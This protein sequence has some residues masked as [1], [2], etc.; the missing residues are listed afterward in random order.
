MGLVIGNLQL[1]ERE[2]L[3]HFKEHLTVVLL[4]VLFIVIPSQLE[5]RQL[6]LLDVRTVGF[7]LAILLVVR[8]LS[9]GCAT[10]GA[11]MRREDR[12]LLAWIAPRGIVAAATAGS[13]RPELMV[14]GYADAEGCCPSRSS[15]S[16]PGCSSTACRL[17]HSPAGSASRRTATTG[18]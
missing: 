10:T 3:Q 9:I 11:S 14:A 12:I 5:P 1:V 7:V 15:S 16:S 6:A 18:C 2:A 13:F 8:P 17:H 4:S